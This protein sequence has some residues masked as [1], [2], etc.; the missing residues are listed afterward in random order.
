MASFEKARQILETRFFTGKTGNSVLSDIPVFLESRE[1]TQ[2][3][4]QD[5]IVMS[6]D[7][8]A[9]AVQSFTGDRRVSGGVV[10]FTVYCPH[11]SGTKRVREI[12]DAIDSV[13]SFSA[14]SNGIDSSSSLYC[15]A[16]SINR[17][18]EDENGYLSYKVMFSYKLYT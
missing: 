9:S 6:I 7:D 3:T 16:G 11:G 4:G 1:I 5:W 10:V 8:A 2:P 13:M 18:S 17:I 14:G 12:A 15:Q